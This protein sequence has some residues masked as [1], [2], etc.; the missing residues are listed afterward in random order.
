MNIKTSYIGELNGVKGVWCGFKPEGLVVEKEVPVYYADE[1]KTFTKDGKFYSSVVLQ[2]GEKIEDYVEVV[3]P[4]EE[5]E[6][7]HQDR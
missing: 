5:E 7:V 6:N 1:G 4:K 3:A 2:E